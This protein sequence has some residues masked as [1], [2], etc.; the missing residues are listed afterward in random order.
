MRAGFGLCKRP[1][2]GALALGLLVCASV[3]GQE[4]RFRPVE[5]VPST[6]LVCLP[7]QTNQPFEGQLISCGDTEMK[8][9]SAGTGLEVKLFMEMAGWDPDDSGLPLLGAYQGSVLTDDVTM[10][11][12]EWYGTACAAAGSTPAAYGVGTD[13]GQGFTGAYQAMKICGTS[14]CALNIFDPACSWDFLTECNSPTDCPGGFPY[15]GDRVDNVFFGIDDTPVVSTGT[16]QWLWSSAS[17]DCTSDGR[18]DGIFGYT[19]CETTAD[20][21]AGETCVEPFFY[22]GTLKIIVPA[23]ANGT[24]SVRLV[25]STDFT[26][27]TSC[28][29]G[30]IPNTGLAPGIVTILCGSCCAA[31]GTGSDYCVDDLTYEECQAETAPVAFRAEVDCSVACFE[32][33]TALDCKDKHPDQTGDDNLCTD[34]ACVNNFC[35]YTINFD[36]STHCCHPDT[37]VPTLID[38][39]DVCTD[40][41]CEWANPAPPFD[42]IYGDDV[43]TPN[44]EDCNDG[45]ACT[46]DDQCGGGDY[47]AAAA[48]GVCQGYQ[49]NYVACTTLGLTDQACLLDGMQYEC[50]D[51]PVLD[52]GNEPATHC[53]CQLCTPLLLDAVPSLVKTDNCYV[54]G[55]D[56]FVD[57]EI[58]IGSEVITGGQFAVS[59]DPTCLD[60]QSIGKL[61]GSIFNVNPYKT[62]DEV[63]GEIFYVSLIE[64]FGRCSIDGAVCYD[65][66]AATDCDQTTAQDCVMT[67]GTIGPA[68]LARIHFKKLVDDCDKCPICFAD[69]NPQNLELTNDKGYAVTLCDLE[70]EAVRLAG[71]IDIVGPVLPIVPFYSDC[72]LSSALVTWDTVYATDTCD[73]PDPQVTCWGDFVDVYQHGYTPTKGPDDLKMNGGV[74]AQGQWWFACEATNSCGNKAEEVWTV[75][76]KDKHVLDVEVHLAPPIE[77]VL[78]RCITFVLYANCYDEPEMIKTVIDFGPPDHFLGHG[79]AS[80]KIPKNNYMCITAEDQLHTLRQMAD[81]ECVDNAWQA[82]WKGDPLLGGNWLPG[83]NLDGYKK[84]EET[85]QPYVIDVLDFGKFMADLASSGTVDGPP[86]GTGDTDCTT[87]GPHADINGDGDVDSDDYAIIQMNFLMAKKDECC[88]D[89]AAPEIVPVIEISVKE[90]R[91]RGLADLVVADLNR[92]GVL[93]VD[94]MAAY[95]AGVRPVQDL[96]IRKRGTR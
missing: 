51:E 87:P 6:N 92:D 29:G 66:V 45:N 1:L 21:A 53:K 77:A 61:A 31:I 59:Y 14:Q 9:S 26:L 89:R 5:A 74:F 27:L 12:T 82:V 36:T 3:Q 75:W 49:V 70:C 30:L 62:V 95:E 13:T 10:V 79:N 17:S 88:P 20:C 52:D 73:D 71:V 55:E 46:Y 85:S 4:M 58:G 24:Y 83:G 64:P 94:D 39:G 69:V 28:A 19:E 91:A 15:C 42:Y 22:G 81:I 47:P 41:T 44:N 38:D 23:G 48:P 18:C 35:E 78:S 16:A 40:D 56:V 8:L 2:V 93:N 60:F 67:E 63:A 7:G 34:A 80:I 54:A 65:L 57:V 33:F 25:A 90:L 32:C 50:T 68:V 76:V 86:Y 84:T 96:R 43:H 11:R 37:G 72:G